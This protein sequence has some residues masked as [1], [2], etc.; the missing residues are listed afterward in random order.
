MIK[1]DDENV[2][3][4]VNGDNIVIGVGCENSSCCGGKYHLDIFGNSPRTY[5]KGILTKEELKKLGEIIQR[6]TQ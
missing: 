3:Q 6:L 5:N 4:T 2:V 1:F